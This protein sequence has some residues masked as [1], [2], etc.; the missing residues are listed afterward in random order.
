LTHIQ[1][2][3]ATQ[4]TNPVSS[5]SWA[6][7]REPEVGTSCLDHSPKQYS[8]RGGEPLQVDG[9]SGEEGLDLH[10]VEA[11]VDGA[12]ETMPGLSFANRNDD[13]DGDDPA[14]LAAGLHVGGVDPQVRPVAFERPVEKGLHL[15]VDLR[16]QAR[17]L[18]FGDAA[19]A[20]GLDRVVTERMDTPSM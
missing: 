16:A 15:A 5:Y 6:G 4:K 2:H 19:H 10:V 17:D 14:V 12:G 1:P 13:G 20:H 18:A 8:E 9:G 3:R 11:A 7:E